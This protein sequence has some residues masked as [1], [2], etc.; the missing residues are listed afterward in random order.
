[1]DVPQIQSGNLSM[2]HKN[3]PTHILLWIRAL[4]LG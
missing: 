2:N 1:M 4:S 3:A